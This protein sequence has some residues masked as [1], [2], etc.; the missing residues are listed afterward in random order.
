METILLPTLNVGVIPVDRPTVPNALVIS[1]NASSVVIF[2]SNIT[3]KYVE[4]NTTV[5][6][7]TVITAAFLNAS[8]GIAYL[9]PF[10]FY[11]KNHNKV[12]SYL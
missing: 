2:E 1:N 12:H 11:K 8:L 9:N 5:I 4:I 7:K 3:N 6:A 10:S